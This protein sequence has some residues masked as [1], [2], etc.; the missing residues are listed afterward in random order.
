MTN[1]LP[2]APLPEMER[3]TAT[4]PPPIMRITI[5]VDNNHCHRYAICQHEAPRVF[6]LANDGR[7]SYNSSPDPSELKAV[8]QAARVCPMQAIAVTTTGGDQ[9]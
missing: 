9:G 3:W 5:S 1:Y 2:P 4:E 7:L 6:L 8:W